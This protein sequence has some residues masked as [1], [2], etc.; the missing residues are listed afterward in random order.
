MIL[1]LKLWAIL[2]ISHF[3]K[4]TV[5]CFE[6]TKNKQL[7]NFPFNNVGDFSACKDRC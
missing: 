6:V 2:K 4:L 7:F 5:C 1:H 3:L